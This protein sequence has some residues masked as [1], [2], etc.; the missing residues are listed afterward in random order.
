MPNLPASIRSRIRDCQADLALRRGDLKTALSLIE[1]ITPDLDAHPFYRFLGLTAVRLALAQGQK[2]EASRILADCLGR[3]EQNGWG[4]GALAVRVSQALAEDTQEAGLAALTDA[5]QR[6]QPEGF[7]RL[8]ADCGQSLIPLLQEAA[9]GGV[10]PLYVG[11]ILAAIGDQALPNAG[12]LVESTPGLVE[13]LSPRELEVLRL[14]A[15]GLS[16]RE[17]AARLVVSTGTVK[18]HVHHICGKLGVANRTQAVVQAR[19]LKII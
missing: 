13:A 3:A 6:S 4:Y 19:D 2:V 10:H 7:L 17:I 15:A 14:M 18:T 8:Y 1:T 11:E 9:R 12:R 5:L 16:N